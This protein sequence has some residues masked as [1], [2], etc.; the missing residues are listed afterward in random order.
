MPVKLCSDQIRY[1]IL[2]RDTRIDKQ[3]F[4]MA[5]DG[6]YTYFCLSVWILVSGGVPVL[7]K[8]TALKGLQKRSTENEKKT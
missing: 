4:S 7:N 2:L 6:L 5:R 1:F 8:H 3:T